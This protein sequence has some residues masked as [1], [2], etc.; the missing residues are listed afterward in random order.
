MFMLFNLIV[1]VG[2]IAIIIGSVG[3]SAGNFERLNPATLGLAV[4][5]PAII[6]VIF[7]LA[8]WIPMLAVHVRRFHD[9]DKSGWFAAMGYISYLSGFAPGNTGL[10]GIAFLA[11]VVLIIFMCI[12]G[13]QGENRFGADPKGMSNLGEVFS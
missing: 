13:T 7:F 4:G 2:L 5:L 10:S 6:M 12:G 9:Q 1:Y 11:W 8:T 3:F